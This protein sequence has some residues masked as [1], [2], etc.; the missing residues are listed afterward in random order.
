MWNGFLWGKCLVSALFHSGNFAGIFKYVMIPRGF[1]N[2]H[3][4]YKSMNKCEIELCCN[5]YENHNSELN[6]FC[7][8]KPHLHKH[9]N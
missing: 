8:F 4:F 2:G 6:T 7:V 3:M 1:G 5:F 9:E